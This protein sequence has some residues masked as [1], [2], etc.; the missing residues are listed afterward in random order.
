MLHDLEI[1]RSGGLGRQAAVF[2]GTDGKVSAPRQRGAD[3]LPTIQIQI[4]SGTFPFASSNSKS[5]FDLR[6]G[7]GETR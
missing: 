4:A 5:N 3:Y 2:P 1:G 6:V 7:E